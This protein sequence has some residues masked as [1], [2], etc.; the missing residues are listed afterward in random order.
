[1]ISKSG[2]Q[3]IQYL[4]S[5][6]VYEDILNINKSRVNKCFYLLHLRAIC[7]EARN[8]RLSCYSFFHNTRSLQEQ[9]KY[10]A[11]VLY[12][13]IWDSS[14][15]KMERIGKIPMAETS[16][17][18]KES[19]DFPELESLAISTNDGHRHDKPSFLCSNYLYED[20]V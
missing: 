9:I 2:P 20:E 1:M 19:S 10:I 6:K 5:P 14:A 17:T 8:G 4:A 7:I 13:E 15:A 12:N 16:F 11:R 18:L 3:I